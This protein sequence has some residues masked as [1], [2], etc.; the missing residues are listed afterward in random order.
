M[1]PKRGDGG[2]Y[3][4][5]HFRFESCLANGVTGRKMIIFKDIVC[6]NDDFSHLEG[7]PCPLN[8][9]DEIRL[10]VLRLPNK[11]SAVKN[12]PLTSDRIR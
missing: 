9:K 11:S 5:L 4:N 8:Q 1:N 2:S 3:G 7:I 12:L 10:K 6:P